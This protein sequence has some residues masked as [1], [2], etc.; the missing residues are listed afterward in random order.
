MQK[1]PSYI[2]NLCDN[3]PDKIKRNARGSAKFVHRFP[4]RSAGEKKERKEMNRDDFRD[5]CRTRRR[6]RRAGWGGRVSSPRG[7]ELDPGENKGVT[8]ESATRRYTEEHMGQTESAT[9]HGNRCRAPEINGAFVRNAIYR[10]IDTERWLATDSPETESLR[11]LPADGEKEPVNFGGP[12]NE[13]AE[14]NIVNWLIVLPGHEL[15]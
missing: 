12:V 1:I 9:A 10:A 15:N 3:T 11:T 4:D 13:S 14:P 8:A 7:N 5:I 6:K 2:F